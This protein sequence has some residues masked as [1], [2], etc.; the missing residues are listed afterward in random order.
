MS[1][2]CLF[3]NQIDTI[4]EKAK[5]LISQILQTFISR[6][7]H[8][9]I[10]L[11]KSLVIPILKYCSVLWSPSAVE[12]IQRLEEIQKSFLKQIKGTPKN[13]WESLSLK[14]RE[15]EG[16]SAIASYTLGK[17]RTKYQ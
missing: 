13:Y 5:N 15:G 11:Y 1:N 8:T 7:T 14:Y 10:T 4:I 16:E 3:K 9:M 17:S 2:N 6:T 12:L